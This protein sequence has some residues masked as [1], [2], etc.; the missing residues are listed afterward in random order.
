[1][2]KKNGAGGGDFRYVFF[3][4]N[5]DNFPD[6]FITLPFIPIDQGGVSCPYQ[7]NLW[8]IKIISGQDS[9]IPTGSSL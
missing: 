9:G 6:I 1:M 3:L 8:N 5:K 4:K 7:N 2:L